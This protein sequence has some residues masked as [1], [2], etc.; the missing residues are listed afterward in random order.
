MASTVVAAAAR[1]IAAWTVLGQLLWVV[2]AVT[3]A[4]TSLTVVVAV[5]LFALEIGVPFLIERRAG[6][7]PWHPHHLAERYAL[8]TIIALGEIVVGTAETV[9]ALHAAHGWTPEVM[10]VLLASA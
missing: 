5:V 6:G 4:P 8:L 1:K 10:L 2:V 7:T 3:A 9:R